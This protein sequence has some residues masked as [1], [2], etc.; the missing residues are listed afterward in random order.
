M[1][2]YIFKVNALDQSFVYIF[3]CYQAGPDY[4]KPLKTY[5]VAGYEKE[6][7]Q[8]EHFDAISFNPSR[9]NPGRREKNNLKVLFSH[10]F[11]VPHEGL[12]D[13]HKTF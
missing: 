12:K 9:P 1:Y 6:F 11:V 10:F 4:C 13:R 8:E 2:Y 5:L 7:P 3:T